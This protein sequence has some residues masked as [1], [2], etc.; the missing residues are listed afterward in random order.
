MFI[1]N[2]N[3]K[4][5]EFITIKDLDKRSENNPLAAR[6][7]LDQ[8]YNKKLQSVIIEGG[9]KTIQHFIDADL[10]DE[11]RIFVTK[12]KMKSGLEGPKIKRDLIYSTSKI[13]ED[14]LITLYKDS[15]ISKSD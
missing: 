2:L 11:A 6:E 14:T 10:W 9:A 15:T 1:G 4:S 5:N 7:I 3:L 12:T 8:L 13:K